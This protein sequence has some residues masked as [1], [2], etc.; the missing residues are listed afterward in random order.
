LLFSAVYHLCGT[1]N[2][3]WHMWLGYWD[4][5]GIVSL[6]VGSSTPV[7]HYGFGPTLHTH[8][9]L[10]H[11]A[12]FLFGMVVI[13]C[14]VTTWF[15]SDRWLWARV[16]VY[17]ALAALGVLALF[18]ALLLHDF[19]PPRV[20][21][22]KGVLQMGLTYLFGAAVYGLRLPESAFPKRFDYIGSSHQLWHA[23]VVLA[24]YQHFTVVL[25]LWRSM[26]EG[27]PLGQAVAQAMAQA[28]TLPAD[29]ELPTTLG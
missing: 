15:N 7:I 12:T 28:I 2:E 3:R 14:S 27:P 18:H 9:Q 10:Y 21:L 24:A 6:I 20:R 5:A 26:S 16:G 22:M 29:L 19:S 11:V 4:F 23:C 8:R 25:Q 1:A 13:V 17:I